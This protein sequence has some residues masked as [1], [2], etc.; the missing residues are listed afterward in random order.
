M[1]TNINELISKI[2]MNKGRDELSIEDELSLRSDLGFDSFD[3]AE[4]TVKIDDQFGIDIFEK[5]INLDKVKE[6]Y[7]LLGLE[8]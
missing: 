3:L 6:I 8:V 2:A 5:N 1:K 7:D 4:L